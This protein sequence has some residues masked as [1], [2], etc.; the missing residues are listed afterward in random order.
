MFGISLQ[1]AP[2]T[3][4]LADDLYLGARAGA[5]FRCCV[6]PQTLRLALSAGLLLELTMGPHPRV[7][8]VRDGRLVLAHY[9]VA[10]VDETT[11]TVISLMTE[12][13]T[14]TDAQLAR[15]EVRAWVELLAA[16]SA[17]LVERRLR[18]RGMLVEVLPRR[19]LVASLVRRG[20][21][22]R[23]PEYEPVDSNVTGTV[24]ARLHNVLGSGEQLDAQDR[25]L[26]ALIGATSMLATMLPDVTGDTRTSYNEQ[27]SLLGPHQRAICE[28]AGVL[29]NSLA[30]TR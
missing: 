11:Q 2:A 23:G 27:V 5:G 21:D 17:Q 3:N 4:S 16:T 28:A 6:Q 22:G 13:R 15:L 18:E 24:V 19:S 14:G 10:P 30:Q 8:A 1:E 20:R 7:T 29:V 12:A 25:I 26:A 9:G